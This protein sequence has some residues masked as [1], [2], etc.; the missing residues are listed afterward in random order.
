MHSAYNS[1]LQSFMYVDVHVCIHV[2]VY[3]SAEW[4]DMFFA[5]HLVLKHWCET[6]LSWLPKYSDPTCCI[7]L[8]S[9]N[10]GPDPTLSPSRITYFKYIHYT[11]TVSESC[12]FALH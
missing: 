6:G 11:E 12:V 2:H 8:H 1:N 3:F 10:A 7:Y 9:V 5:H 4:C